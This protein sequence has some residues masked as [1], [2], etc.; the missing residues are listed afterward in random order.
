MDALTF[1][2]VVIVSAMAAFIITLAIF[3]WW[4]ER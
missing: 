4:D 1:T 3:S 2:L